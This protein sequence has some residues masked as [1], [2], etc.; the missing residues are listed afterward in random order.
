M[1]GFESVPYADLAKAVYEFP[2]LEKFRH[3][4]PNLSNDKMGGEY[5]M[6]EWCL[7]LPK[8]STLFSAGY[9]FRMPFDYSI[10]AKASYAFP[11]PVKVS[12]L[13]YQTLE[14]LPRSSSVWRLVNTIGL[15]DMDYYKT[16]NPII[17]NIYNPLEY[18][19]Q[20]VKGSKLLQGVLRGFHTFQEYDK[21]HMPTDTR[22]G[23]IGSTG[24]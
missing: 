23:G 24:A 9:D 6:D 4:L 12:M 11:L 5:D 2:V 20:L 16:G 8:R 15:I 14:L 19:L 17:A 22:K 21:I 10:P 3:F 18:S 7:D 13:P 1:Y